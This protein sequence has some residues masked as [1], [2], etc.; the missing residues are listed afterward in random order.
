MVQSESKGSGIG[1]VVGFLVGVGVG[2]LMANKP[3][4]ETRRDIVD[5]FNK[6]RR[7]SEELIGQGKE[8]LED[9]KS[10]M[11]SEGGKEPFY[12]SGKYV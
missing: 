10:G 1:G 5:L 9:V 7:K 4:S 8:R 3:G 2:L 11:S 6:G 12:E